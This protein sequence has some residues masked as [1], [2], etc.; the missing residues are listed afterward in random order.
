MPSPAVGAPGHVPWRLTRHVTGR[1]RRD[2]KSC[3]LSNIERGWAVAF[4]R[5]DHRSSESGLDELSYR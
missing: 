1:S 5:P 2:A 3:S 4:G